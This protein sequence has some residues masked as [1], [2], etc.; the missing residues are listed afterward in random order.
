LYSENEEKIFLIKENKKVRQRIEDDDE[1]DRL[2]FGG[3]NKKT[4]KFSEGEREF[5]MPKLSL[6]PQNTGGPR[7]KNRNFKKLSQNNTNNSI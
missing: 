1:E 7:A 5:W 2:S 3:M 6:E 4:P